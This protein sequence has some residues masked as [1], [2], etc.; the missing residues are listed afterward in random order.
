[1]RSAILQSD[2]Y[3]VSSANSGRS[4]LKMMVEDKFDVVLLDFCMPDMDGLQ[5]ASEARRLE[6]RSPILIVSGSD[7]DELPEQVFELTDGFI[8]KGAPPLLLLDRVRELT[9]RER[10]LN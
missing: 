5:V 3:D 8:Q 9:G 4:G 7:T 2:G 6:V 1:M 10:V